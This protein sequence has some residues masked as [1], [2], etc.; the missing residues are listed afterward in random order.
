MNFEYDHSVYWPALNRLAE[1]RRQAQRERW[2]K[3][4]KSVGELE[5]Y[6]KG[7]QEKC[8]RDMD[9]RQADNADEETG[10]QQGSQA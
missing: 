3:G 4:G 10:G 8:L 2:V 6:L 9:A 7:G 1:E 5:S